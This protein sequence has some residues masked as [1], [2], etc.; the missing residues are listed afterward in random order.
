MIYGARDKY[1]KSLEPEEEK[2]DEQSDGD[3]KPYSDDRLVRAIIDGD[4]D[5]VDR[6]A[7]WYDDAGRDF[8]KSGVT[9]NLKEIWNDLPESERNDI[10]G[11]L[12]RYGGYDPDT[13]AKWDDG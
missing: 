12:I 1:L 5:T 6:I 11:L 2:E 4:E 8:P 3:V 9:S 7:S 10:T 13:I